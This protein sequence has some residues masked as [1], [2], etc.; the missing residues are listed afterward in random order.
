MAFYKENEGLDQLLQR[1]WD[2]LHLLLRIL[3]V[4][5]FFP[6]NCIY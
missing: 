3:E 1:D 4:C 5:I 6:F 2:A